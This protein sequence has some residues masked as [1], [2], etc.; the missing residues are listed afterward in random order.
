MMKSLGIFN[1]SVTMLTVERIKKIPLQNQKIRLSTTRNLVLPIKLKDLRTCLHSFKS[2]C[3][4]ESE[5][6]TNQRQEN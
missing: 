4:A 2:E 1:Q 5:K 6:A 3:P